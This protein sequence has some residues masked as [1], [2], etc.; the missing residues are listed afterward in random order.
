ML[1]PDPIGD[2]S[3][4][5]DFPCP[6]VVRPFD[7]GRWRCEA[8]LRTV[9]IAGRREHWIFSLLLVV[10]VT[11]PFGATPGGRARGSTSAANGSQ[12]RLGIDQFGRDDDRA[13]VCD[14]YINPYFMQCTDPDRGGDASKTVFD[15][16]EGILAGAAVGYG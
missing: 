4:C 2:L 15:R 5:R 8:I 3:L 6:V 12:L 7:Q 13:S 10:I 9:L 16:A 14:E 11:Y 1:F